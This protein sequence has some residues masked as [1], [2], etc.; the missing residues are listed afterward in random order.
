MTY[1]Q[2]KK[3]IDS[4]TPAQQRQKV[5][6]Y[7]GMIDEATPVHGFSDNSD[8]DMGTPLPGYRTSQVFL[9]IE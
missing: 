8:E 2:L 5:T 4:M 7:S 9:L 1:L 6:V 3:L